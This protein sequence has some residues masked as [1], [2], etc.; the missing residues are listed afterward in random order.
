MDPLEEQPGE[1]TPP[2]PQ[3]ESRWEPIFLVSALII[4]LVTIV[5]FYLD[6]S[7]DSLIGLLVSITAAFSYISIKNRKV[8]WFIAG[9]LVVVAIIGIVIVCWK[10]TPPKIVIVDIRFDGAGK[11]EPDEYVLIRNDGRSAINLKGWKLYDKDQLIEFVFPEFVLQPKQ[12][13]RIYTNELHTDTCG[14]NLECKRAI[15]SNEGDCAYLNDPEGNPP[16]E[17]CY[18]EFAGQSVPTP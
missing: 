10:P 2:A 15:W 16:R 13:C 7:F 4:I 8:N 18:G 3:P 17:F 1:E 9:A 5:W 6:R 14:F 11:Q 12:E